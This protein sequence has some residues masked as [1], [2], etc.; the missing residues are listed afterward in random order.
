MLQLHTITSLSASNCPQLAQQQLLDENPG[1]KCSRPFL[2]SVFL[3]V[4]S[5]VH[6]QLQTKTTDWKILERKQSISL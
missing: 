4:V 6:N 5:G 1:T 3:F 2:S